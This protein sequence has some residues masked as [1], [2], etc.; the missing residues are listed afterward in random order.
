ME[1]K[2]CVIEP[3]GTDRRLD[4]FLK[5]REPSF[6]RVALQEHVRAG[7]VLVDGKKVKPHHKLKAGEVVSWVLPDQDACSLSAEDIPLDIIFEDQD[8]LVIDKPSGLVVHPGA[9]NDKHT[10]VHALLFHTS[11]LS[12]V[13]AERPGIVHRL[14]KDTSGVMV[15]AKN[16][17]SHLHLARQ[18]KAH[19]IE[20]RYIALVEGAVEF[21]EG[22]VDV[23]IK[24]HLLDRRRMSVSFSGEAKEAQTFY[25]VLKRFPG[26]TAVALFPQTGR[27]HQ[28]RV[29]L[30]YLGHPVLGDPTYGRSGLFS[31]LALHAMNLGFEHPSTGQMVHFSSPLPSAMK[32]AM[33]GVKI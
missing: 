8:I 29:H 30:K 15:I 2:S 10:L 4:L 18:F 6:S 32:K 11:R 28:L 5:E 20:R 23:P 7:R 19:T 24:R 21:D 22:I 9:G 33:P 14:D 17:K 16:N 27:T 31:R 26:Y 3:A 25:Q 13:S 12:S 1:N